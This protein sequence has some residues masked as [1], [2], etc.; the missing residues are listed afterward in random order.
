MK[1]TKF[2][3]RQIRATLH[4]LQ[5]GTK[6]SAEVW[7]RY[8]ETVTSALSRGV[9]LALLTGEPGDVLE[10]SSSNYGYQIATLKIKVGSK[11]LASMVIDFQIEGVFS[12]SRTAIGKGI[13][14]ETGK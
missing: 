14:K 11:N 2:Y 3:K 1:A 5:P 8:Y 13:F 6:A 4:R 9:N 7:T 10:L 12:D